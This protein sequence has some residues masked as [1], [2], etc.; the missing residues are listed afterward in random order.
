MTSS[1]RVVALACAVVSLVVPATAAASRLASD[2]ERADIVPAAVAGLD[3]RGVDSQSYQAECP[4]TLIST[5]D[6]RWALV[7]PCATDGEYA[8]VLVTQGD[9][10]RWRF[11]GIHSTE[12]GACLA[13]DTI[14]A[15]V[16]ADL[17]F[18]RKPTTN[19]LCWPLNGDSPLPSARPRTCDVFGDPGDFAH[20]ARLRAMKWTAWGGPIAKA[21][22]A[23]F[24]VHPGQGGKASVPVRLTAF[25]KR[26]IC[27]GDFVYTR[28]TMVTEYGTRTLA[29]G[30]CK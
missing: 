30:D 6:P 11:S 4:T 1:A 19:V 2:A 21:S 28:L 20:A 25:R 27:H 7:D 10:L 26:A 16:E 3:A 12:P 5:A 9:D 14:P 22:G 23:S 15:S 8:R 24:S 18:C 29:I 13:T 17:K